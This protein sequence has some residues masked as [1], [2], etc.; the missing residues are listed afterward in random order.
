[1]PHEYSLLMR[2]V[3]KCIQLLYGFTIVEFD[4][5]DKKLF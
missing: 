4:L 2:F 3:L 1:V 5:N